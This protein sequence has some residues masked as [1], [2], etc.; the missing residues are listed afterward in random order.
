MSHNEGREPGTDA[1]KTFTGFRNF[2]IG[3]DDWV[4]TVNSAMV[5]SIVPGIELSK[6][7][8]E[9][10]RALHGD[11][12][13]IT[14]NFSFVN[15]ALDA[16]REMDAIIQGY[17]AF[18]VGVHSMTNAQEFQ[19]EQEQLFGAWTGEETAK[20]QQMTEQR[21]QQEE[22]QE[23]PAKRKAGRP[24]KDKPADQ[25]GKKKSKLDQVREARARKRDTVPNDVVPPELLA[26]RAK[27]NQ[28]VATHSYAAGKDRYQH[29][30]SREL[31]TLPLTD[32]GN[33]LRLF[34]RYGEVLRY[35]PEK[36]KF[37]YWSERGIWKEDTAGQYVRDMAFKTL[38]YLDIEAKLLPLPTDRDGNVIPRPEVAMLR[39][40]TPAEQDAIVEYALRDQQYE[41]LIKWM[42]KSQ[43][44]HSITAMVKEFGALPGVPTSLLD[45]DALDYRL[46]C[47]NGI[48]DLKTG[49]LLPH[50]P[51]EL[52]TKMT[53]CDFPTNPDEARAYWEKFINK[54]TG[55]NKDLQ[56]FLQ[57]VI[58]EG[59]AGVQQDDMLPVCY[60]P[61]SN[62][63]TVFSEIIKE[64][65]GDYAGT[66][67]SDLFLQRDSEGISNDKA[68]LVGVRFL[69][70]SETDE[71]R[72][73]NEA[74]VK[75]LTGGDTQT[76]RFLYGEFFSMTPKFTPLLLTNHKP[77]INGTDNGIWRRVKLVPWLHNFETDPEREDKPA[78]MSKL[79]AELSGILAWA[80]SGYQD[81]QSYGKLYIPEEVQ[82]ETKA[83]RVESDTL[84]E[85]LED[86]CVIGG[87]DLM[88]LRKDLY[89]K[90]IEFAGGAGMRYTMTEKSF[91][92]KLKDRPDL[93]V[94]SYRDGKARR[95]WTGIR[96]LEDGETP[97]ERPTADKQNQHTNEQ[98]ASE[99]PGQASLPI[100]PTADQ[101][102]NWP[103][104]AYQYAGEP[105]SYPC[106]KHPDGKWV[107]YYSI[108][109]V[110]R[111]ACSECHPEVVASKGAKYN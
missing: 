100:I 31:A 39:D 70:A 36:S 61:G 18:N 23:Q 10:V 44:S 20:F 93:N 81:R 16:Y 3:L 30:I 64:V 98:P 99:Q 56:R 97:P 80:F 108:D 76:V 37:F 8:D 13:L 69:T 11:S 89:D 58:G 87:P 92:M 91:A 50:D 48:L 84:G 41:G 109:E 111:Y 72:K 95:Y 32:F 96:L 51:K 45:F 66:A 15:H 6:T 21:N 34:Y 17:H 82:N 57:Q 62:G 43:S 68:A 25:D 54:I 110:W 75:S 101:I 40:A 83:Y 27:L 47:R 88:V 46:N 78:V 26:K 19:Q 104:D 12:A 102:A 67:S 107:P 29:D 106:M 7:V 53:G 33:A 94:G 24:R 85:F 74:T 42:I 73:L 90:Y 63:K 1:L 9:A 77:I 49:E 65:M 103:D 105:R 14:D 28:Y 86:Y 55:G 5:N 35:V 52:H 22:Q 59:L 71:G 38:A 60:G 2:R 4:Q 79:R